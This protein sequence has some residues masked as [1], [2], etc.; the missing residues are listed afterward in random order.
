MVFWP[1][2]VLLNNPH[3]IVVSDFDPDTDPVTHLES[4]SD[5][6]MTKGELSLSARCG[7]TQEYLF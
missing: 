4:G 5:D 2:D 6:N 3:W 1:V 7:S